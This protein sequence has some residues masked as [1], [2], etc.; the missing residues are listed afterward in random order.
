MIPG[1]SFQQIY[2]IISFI[3]KLYLILEFFHSANINSPV[4]QSSELTDADKWDWRYRSSPFGGREQK[5][6]YYSPHGDG[7]SGDSAE[8]HQWEYYLKGAMGETLAI[9]DGLQYIS[10]VNDKSTRN[11]YMFAS[12]YII[13]G[14]DLLYEKHDSSYSMT[15]QVKD[16]LGST[17][18]KISSR[19]DSS[20]VS[21]M[22]FGDSL[23]VSSGYSPRQG[24][25]GN[26]RDRENSYTAMGARLYDP[27][28]GIFLS[29]DPLAE[30]FPERSPYMYAFNS[31]LNFSDP[32]GLAPKKEKGRRSKFQTIVF[33]LKD[34]LAAYDAFSS[35][36]GFFQNSI[37]YKGEL[38]VDNTR[39]IFSNMTR[40]G[41]MSGAG[42][43]GVKY[44]ISKSSTGNGIFSN[45]YVVTFLDNTGKIEI[46]V[47]VDMFAS[48]QYNP[49]ELVNNYAAAQAHAI[50][51]MGGVSNF[52]KY[53]DIR[54][55]NI[56]GNIGYYRNNYGD[57]V[58]LHTARE[59]DIYLRADVVMGDYNPDY[60]PNSNPLMPDSGFWGDYQNS[61]QMCI[62]LLST[63]SH[64]IGH[65]VFWNSYPS[66]LW[67]PYGKSDYSKYL[68]IF[69]DKFVNSIGFTSPRYDP[70]NRNGFF[71]DEYTE[72]I[73]IW[74][75]GEFG[76]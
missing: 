22:P 57:A 4:I 63:L 34:P 43:G 32:S 70:Y 7:P 51:A 58:G 66:E 33:D 27:E 25:Y 42:G 11:V 44:L 9:Y 2:L 76:N 56:V 37:I 10:N 53:T 39:M 29:V 5:R 49:E 8:V 55:I 3:A 14:G 71:T 45:N 73:D 26:Q 61:N 69:A 48:D 24:Y 65:N 19:G 28:L 13:A 21:Y 75:I 52:K 72:L 35:D 17:R 46:P 68:E 23:N 12:R 50:E 60:Q 30:L 16:H 74:L 15:L 64:E 36:N 41:P 18:L 6:L 47:R 59:G 38:I 54:R 40:L 62:T 20:Y 31:P 1:T 67:G